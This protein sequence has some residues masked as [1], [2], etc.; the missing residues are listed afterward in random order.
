MLLCS[1]VFVNI[2]VPVEILVTYSVSCFSLSIDSVLFKNN[3]SGAIPKELG[4][5]TKLEQLDLRDNN[6]SGA[7]PAEIGRMLSLKHL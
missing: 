1:L 2:A 6:L 4:Q 5:L 3:F 7:I